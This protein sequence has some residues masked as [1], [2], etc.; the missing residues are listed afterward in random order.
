MPVPSKDMELIHCCHW[1]TC[2][3]TDGTHWTKKFYMLTAYCS[4]TLN[5][6]PLVLFRKIHHIVHYL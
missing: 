6:H 3:T 2:S 5:H 1:N 4:E